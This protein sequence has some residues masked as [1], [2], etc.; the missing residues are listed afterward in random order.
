MNNI[1]SCVYDS[2]ANAYMEPWFTTNSQIAV[3]AFANAANAADHP[4]GQNPEDYTLFHIGEWNPQTGEM[5]PYET[6][7]SAG[8]AIE[9]V[10]RE[11]QAGQITM[12]EFLKQSYENGENHE[13]A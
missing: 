11:L 8:L 9:F 2:K 13:T 3:R 5:T 12:D 7:H 1:I 6:K 10:D 4:F